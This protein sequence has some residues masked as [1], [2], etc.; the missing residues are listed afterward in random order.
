M[1]T[2]DNMLYE[3]AVSAYVKRNYTLANI[4]NIKKDTIGTGTNYIITTTDGSYFL[5]F[6]NLTNPKYRIKDEIKVCQYINKITPITS[7]FIKNKTDDYITLYENKLG[8]LAGHLQIYYPSSS[9]EQYNVSKS[10]IIKGIAK[11]GLISQILCNY[12]LPINNLFK[13]LRQGGA[14]IK[15]LTLQQ[16]IMT[17]PECNELIERRINYLQKIPLLD[18]DNFSYLSSHSDYT[19]MQFLIRKDEIFKIIDFSHVSTVPIVWEIIRYI[20]QCIKVDSFERSLLYEMYDLYSSYY[21][22]TAYDYKYGNFLFGLQI[23]QSLYGFKEYLATR[24]P[25][26]LRILTDR[27]TLLQNMLY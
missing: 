16:E 18:L 12:T 4:L 25:K 24:N 22:L 14:A 9:W 26:Y 10:N 5:K 1:K 17:I 15:Y 11:L 27:D 7:I 8:N 13:N 3:E 2:V 19:P 21:K 6:F 20:S 23:A